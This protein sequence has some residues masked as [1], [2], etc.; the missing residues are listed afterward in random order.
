MI[1]ELIGV[2][3]DDKSRTTSNNNYYKS[4]ETIVV[5][6]NNIITTT[7]T[8]FDMELIEKTLEMAANYIVNTKILV[9]SDDKNYCMHSSSTKQARSSV[10]SD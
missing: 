1:F 10:V 7:M 4:S 8:L 9:L 5:Q 2:D 3:C 6:I